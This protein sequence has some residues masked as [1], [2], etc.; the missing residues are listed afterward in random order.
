MLKHMSRDMVK[1]L[2][3]MDN[4]KRV[5]LRI[6]AGD[7]E[8]INRKEFYGKHRAS[9]GIKDKGVRK[10]IG[11][12]KVIGVG[13]VSIETVVLEKKMIEKMLIEKVNIKEKD[14]CITLAFTYN[15]N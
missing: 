12:R 15:N 13:T 9:A 14:I 6:K 4:K 11:G 7:K 3:M 5:V 10:S 2:L 8:D 1:E